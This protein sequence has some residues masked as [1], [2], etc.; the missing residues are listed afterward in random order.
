MALLPA[1]QAADM[2]FPYGAVYFRKSNPPEEDWERDHKT[3]AS[4]GMNIMRHWYMWSG[5]EVATEKYDWRDYDRMIELEGQNGI[6]VVIAEMITAAPEW[7]WKKYPHAR[8][9]AHDGFQGVQSISGSAA[10]G[11]FPG[12][13][14]DNNDV[15]ALAERFLKALA[16]RYKDHPAMY[17]YDLW[18]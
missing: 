1:A 17:G 5:I 12:L 8:F 11:G 9:E 7:V 15:R 13:C 4:I 6:K 16:A 3:A 14:L 18:N 10:T 2:V